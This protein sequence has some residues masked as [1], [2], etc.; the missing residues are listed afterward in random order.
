MCETVF[1]IPCIAVQQSEDKRLFL[2]AI[3]GKLID[4]F[5][6]V[7]RISRKTTDEI[8]GYQRPES[9]RHIQSIRNYVD[10]DSPLIPNAIVIAF[11]DSVRFVPDSSKSWESEEY[12]TSGHLVIPVG[13]E[14]GAVKKPGWIVDGQQRVAAIRGS[15][16]S[17]FPIAVS[18]F[19]A[20]DIEQQREQ[21][22]LVN[23]TKPLPRSLITELLPATSGRLPDQLLRRRLAATLMTRLA[24]DTDSPLRGL[25]LLPTVPEGIIKDNSVLRALENSLT[26]GSLYRFRDRETGMGDVDAMLVPVK[27]FFKSVKNSFSKDWGLRP[28]HSRLFHGVGV[29]SLAYLMDAL[30]E[31]FGDVG[32][33]LDSYFEENLEKIRPHCAWSSGA[34]VFDDCSSVA[35]NRVQN[36][37]QDI[38]RL[39]THLVRLYKATS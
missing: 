28:T 7:S 25:I 33:D 5:A 35:W 27:T 9:L 23:S 24:F 10:S 21:F 1:K 37:S 13:G 30:V 2:F 19:I 32:N 12:V 17:S 11:D 31:D 38:R 8:A 22:I 3:D 6:A 34:W 16:R 36:T 20:A 4:D 29:I 18:A 15:R 39:S 14:P 26:D